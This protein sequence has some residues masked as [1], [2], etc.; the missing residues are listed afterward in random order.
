MEKEKCYYGFT[1]KANHIRYPQEDIY[2]EWMK[3][4]QNRGF[5]I[6]CYYYEIDSL[7]KLHLH[8][9]A[10]APK[11][12]WKKGLLYE[13]MHQL[14]KEIPTLGDLKRFTD[15]IQKEYTNQ[16]EYEDKLTQYHYRTYG[17]ING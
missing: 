9:I 16:K 15:Y 10:I 7:D 3:N 6:Q 5:D 8:G 11:K 14:I 4:A 13:Q 12:L 1:V 17:F 2:I